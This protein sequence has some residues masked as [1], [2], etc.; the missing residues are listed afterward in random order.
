MQKLE[1][2]Y[3][4]SEVK[5]CTLFGKVWQV[6]EKLNTEIPYDPAVPLSFF[7]NFHRDSL[8][9]RDCPITASEQRPDDHLAGI[10]ERR[11]MPGWNC[12]PP[13]SLLALEYA[14]TPVNRDAWV[15]PT[16][17]VVNVTFWLRTTGLMA[18][19]HRLRCPLYQWAGHLWSPGVA[20]ALPKSLR[21]L[22]SSVLL[23]CKLD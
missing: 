12:W 21:A 13:K 9:G 4:T 17:R 14:V 6:L 11:F 16:A 5:W 22:R 2:S 10:V 1:P 7:L 18:S 8:G 20:C 3:T 19:F 23:F 15:Y